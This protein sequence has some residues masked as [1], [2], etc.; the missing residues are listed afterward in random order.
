MRQL[1][2]DIETDGIVATKVH[3]IVAIDLATNEQFVYR[4]DKG[5]LYEFNSLISSPL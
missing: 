2:F 3:C 4:S 5:N 1:A